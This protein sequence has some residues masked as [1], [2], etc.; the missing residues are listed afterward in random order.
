MKVLLV[1][2]RHYPGGGDTTY[3]FNLAAVLRENGHDVSFFAMKDPRNHA[4][5]NEDL[6]VDPIDF[7]ELNRNKTIGGAVTVLTRSIYSSS[8]RRKF[9]MLLDRVAPDIVHFQNIHAHITPSV[10]LEAKARNLPAIW[11]LHDYKL[12][13][14]NSHLYVDTTGHICE[15][16]R[17]G[18][19]HQAIRTRCKKGSL[20]ASAAAALEAYAHSFSNIHQHVRMFI[21]PSSF[22]RDKLIENGYSPD[23]LCVIPYVLSEDCFAST[24]G[25]RGYILYLGKIQRLKGIDTLISAARRIP[26]TQVILAGPDDDPA[27]LNPLPEN[28]RYVGLKQGKDLRELLLG[29][30]AVVLPSQWYE[31]QPLC[32]LEAFAA[33]KPVIASDLGG[34]AELVKDDVRGLLFPKGDMNALSAAMQRLSTN[35]G[36]ARR[37]GVNA[38]E[39]ARAVHHPEAHYQ[40]IRGLYSQVIEGN[41][42]VSSPVRP[43]LN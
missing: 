42:P 29:A 15:A 18:A 12:I 9:A 10:T 11:T 1:N 7:R 6:F 34:M 37:L 28:V 31:N 39:Y 17:G 27:L 16:C 33:A 23:R 40:L 41:L 8:A 19:F 43:G 25:D 30:R 24:D 35:A 3:T 36:Y 21:A 5:P 20:L 4:D 32:I 22:L 13:C 38:Y 26:S 14:P 2:T